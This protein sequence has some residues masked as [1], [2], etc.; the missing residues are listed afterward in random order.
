[1]EH[2]D[3]LAEANNLEW[4]YLEESKAELL[5]RLVTSQ[6]QTTIDN[7]EL[8]LATMVLLEQNH[9]KEYIKKTINIVNLI[10][11]I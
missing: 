6:V 8:F 1:M 4:L 7:D 10:N 11:K 2:I 9:I 3:K 5:I